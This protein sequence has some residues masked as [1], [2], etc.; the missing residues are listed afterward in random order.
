MWLTGS[1]SSFSRWIPMA[2]L[3]FVIDYYFHICAHHSCTVKYSEGSKVVSRSTH[4]RVWPLLY[5]QQIIAPWYQVVGP[6]LLIQYTASTNEEG[7]SLPSGP[8]QYLQPY[9]VPLHTAASLCSDTH[10][11]R[12][13]SPL[14]CSFCLVRAVDP[15]SCDGHDP[16]AADEA[17]Y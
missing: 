8:K 14:I 5:C 3:S 2:F 7:G 9:T 16:S 11:P 10:D 6:I 17:S 15:T 13:G 12:Q 4:E 1:S